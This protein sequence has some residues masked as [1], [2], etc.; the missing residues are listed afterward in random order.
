MKK[1][2]SEYEKI[3]GKVRAKKLMKYSALLPSTIAALT[4]G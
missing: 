1:T 4:P 2:L 3:Y